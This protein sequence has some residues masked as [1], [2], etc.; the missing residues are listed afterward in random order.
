MV[1]VTKENQELYGNVIEALNNFYWDNSIDPELTAARLDEFSREVARLAEYIR[2]NSD[3]LTRVAEQ[4]DGADLA[5]QTCPS[6]LGQGYMPA[7]TTANQMCRTC[8]GTGHV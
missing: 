2:A 7:G 3:G 1:T 8:K 6:C 4:R 5:Q